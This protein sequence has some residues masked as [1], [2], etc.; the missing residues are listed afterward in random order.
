MRRNFANQPSVLLAEPSPTTS[1]RMQSRY[2]STLRP[3]QLVFS[4]RLETC[5]ATCPRQRGASLVSV[6]DRPLD[7][8]ELTFQSGL[9]DEEPR[10]KWNRKLNARQKPQSHMHQMS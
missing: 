8:D 4:S 6:E 7:Y 5:P 2:L 3:R 10:S 1:S 9:F